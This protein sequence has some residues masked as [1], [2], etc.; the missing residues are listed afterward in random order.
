MPVPK[1]SFIQRMIRWRFLIVLNIFV[2]VF[3]GISFGREIIRNHSIG[4]EIT[5]LEEQ[6]D[7]LAAQN[8]EI[9]E[10]KIAI[11]TES[12]IEREARLKLGMK[13]PG[14]T[15]YIIQEQTEDETQGQTTDNPND[16]LG[17]VIEDSDEASAVANPT[18]WWYYFFDKQSYN[19][20][21]EYER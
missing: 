4:S 13:K 17:L 18:K 21:S 16:P 15:V 2:I 12:Y 5:R 20:F 9:S 1:S 10:L 7:S 11:Q 6:A 19:V 14:E 3:L 8:I